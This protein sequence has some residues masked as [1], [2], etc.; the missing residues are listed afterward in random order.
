[1][2]LPGYQPVQRN[3]QAATVGA[4]STGFAQGVSAFT[5]G[6]SIG[7]QGQ[8]VANQ[9]EL[10]PSTIA[11]RESGIKVDESRIRN[12]ELEA[13]FAERTFA[14]RV[15]LFNA[16]SDRAM[17]NY[18]AQE[19]DTTAVMANQTFSAYKAAFGGGGGDSAPA[20]S[21]P[22]PQPALPQGPGVVNPVLFGG[23]GWDTSGG[24]GYPTN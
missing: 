15:E 11:A 16:Q 8:S 18:A 20:S 17:A 1:M 21:N 14:K 22:A 12:M 6:A 10:V 23:G 24:F 2:P 5:G 13:D 7:I 4:F 9:T 3:A 19:V